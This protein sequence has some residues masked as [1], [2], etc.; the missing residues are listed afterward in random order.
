MYFYANFT[1]QHPYSSSVEAKLWNCFV[2]QIKELFLF[3][4]T[5]AVAFFLV[6]WCISAISLRVVLLQLVRQ[7]I[8]MEKRRGENSVWRVNWVYGWACQY[9][10]VVVLL[11]LH[12]TITMLW[13]CLLLHW[14]LQ[15]YLAPV[16]CFGSSYMPSLCTKHPRILMSL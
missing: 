4:N 5:P 11:S 16:D 1:L 7:Q 14:T 9:L 12:E 8:T 6:L 10:N 13:N 3:E 2:S 15:I